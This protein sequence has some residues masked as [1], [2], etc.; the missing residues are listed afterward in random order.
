[1][2]SKTEGKTLTVNSKA[3]PNAIPLS[4]HLHIRTESVVNSSVKHANHMAL[5]DGIF[6]LYRII[7]DY[8][9]I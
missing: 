2:P 5:F 8:Y 3:A 1:M 6:I 9:G 4:S 7:G